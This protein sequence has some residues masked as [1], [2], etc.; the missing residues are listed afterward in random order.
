MSEPSIASRGSV[1]KLVMSMWYFRA[2][3]SSSSSTQSSCSFSL[4]SASSILKM[5]ASSSSS[6]SRPSGTAKLQ[7]AEDGVS[8]F[9]KELIEMDRLKFISSLGELQG[10]DI[11]S[12]NG[13]TS[14]G[15]AEGLR[16][17]AFG[18]CSSGLHE[19]EQSRSEEPC[20]AEAR[21]CS[22]L[23]DA[24]ATWI[25]TDCR[26][27]L[28]PTTTGSPESSAPQC[29]SRSIKSFSPIACTFWL[30]SSSLSSKPTICCR[31]SQEPSSSDASSSDGA[32]VS[33]KTSGSV[34]SQSSP[35]VVKE[36]PT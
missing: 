5:M 3:P 11:G 19:E 24:S 6:S 21:S 35:Q 22:L 33:M 34:S 23:L 29:T 15:A 26:V 10:L 14:N 20:L 12:V 9:S 25:N 17:G 7:D 31:S 1:S 32:P 27:W 28:A 13:S 2:K 18:G 36:V 8:T 30:A 4:S 16:K